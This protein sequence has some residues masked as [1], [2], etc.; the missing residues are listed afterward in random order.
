MRAIKVSFVVNEVT[1]GKPLGDI[2]TGTGY[3]YNQPWWEAWNFQS[4]PNLQGGVW[5]WRLNQSP[6]AND[7]ISHACMM[8]VSIKTQKDTVWRTSRLV[9]MW[10]FGGG[11]WVGSH[12]S[13]KS[14]LYALPYASLPSGYSWVLSFYNGNLVR[15]MFLWILWDAVAN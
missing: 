7:L 5:S 6:L 11:G 4:N 10:R 3:Q 14:F 12:E 9:N 8:K 15:K 1:F 2:N 13:S